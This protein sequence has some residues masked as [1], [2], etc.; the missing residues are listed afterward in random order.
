M[1]KEVGIRSIQKKTGRRNI[2]KE[3]SREVEERE[4]EQ[5][6]KNVMP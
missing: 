4:C 1:L 5:E 2:V 6:Q 3:K